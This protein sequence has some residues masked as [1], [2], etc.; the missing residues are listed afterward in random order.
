MG[1]SGPQAMDTP[2]DVADDLLARFSDFVAAHTGLHFPRKQWRTLE[3]GM[4]CAAREFG[5][6]DP[7]ACLRWIMASPFSRG[8]I[9]I[10]ARHLTVGETYFLREKRSLEVF[11]E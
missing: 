4:A 10:L 5:F 6:E 2:A 1:I 8:Q 9:E 7:E 3:R 11:E